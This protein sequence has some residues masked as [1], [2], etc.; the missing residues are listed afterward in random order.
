LLTPNVETDLAHQ[1]NEL[2]LTDT[3]ESKAHAASV[4]EASCGNNSCS[5]H[6]IP[7]ASDNVMYLVVSRGADI[8]AGVDHDCCPAATDAGDATDSQRRPS[9]HTVGMLPPLRACVIDVGDAQALINSIGEISRLHYGG[10][11]IEL[12]AILTTHK[13][14]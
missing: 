7:F 8:G 10:R 13:H 6:A 2:K 4:G 3:R 1:D 12:E 11:S 14:W 5:I 9:E